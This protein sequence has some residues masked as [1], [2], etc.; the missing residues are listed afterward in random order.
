LV[1]SKIIILSLILNCNNLNTVGFVNIPS[2]DGIDVYFKYVILVCVE[3]IIWN[4]K[5]D[6]EREKKRVE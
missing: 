6:C 2:I 4:K 5:N 3:K 1:G